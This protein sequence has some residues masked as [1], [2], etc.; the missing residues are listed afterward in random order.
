[1]KSFDL[2]GCDWAHVPIGQE[3]FHPIY[4]PTKWNQKHY[5]ENCRYDIPPDGVPTQ[6][7]EQSQKRYV[8]LNLL[9]G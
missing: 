1:M 6:P 5:C 4:E 3:A 7:G 9:N 8:L 2:P